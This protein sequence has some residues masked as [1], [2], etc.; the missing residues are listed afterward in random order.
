[1]NFELKAKDISFETYILTGKIYDKEILNNLIKFIKDN[2]NNEL[3][4]K[5]NVKGYFTGFQSLTENINFLNFIK[6]IQ[7]HIHIIYQNNFK[8]HAAWG[9][10]CEKD[11]E[12]IEHAHNDT[13][14]F[15]GILYLSEGGPGTYFKQY[16]LTINEEIGKFVLFHP[17][18]LHSVQ[19]IKEDIERITVAFNINQIKSWDDL[20]KIKWANNEI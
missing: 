2:K 15:C 4:H 5:T 7:K 1:M 10:I 20:S 18:L 12:V 14:A 8:V 13:T 16:D 3:S 11:G 6:L 9:N 17:Y 19:K